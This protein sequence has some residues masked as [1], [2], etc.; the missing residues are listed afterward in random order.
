MSATLYTSLGIGN[1]GTVRTP[2]EH[3][4]KI[5]VATRAADVQGAPA[6]L[7]GMTVTRVAEAAGGNPGGTEVRHIATA[8]ALP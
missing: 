4:V 5:T 7:D 6:T 8:I 3:T 1:N 2:A